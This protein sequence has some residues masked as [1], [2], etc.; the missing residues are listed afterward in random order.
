MKYGSISGGSKEAVEAAKQ[1]FYN[2]GNAFDAGI[3]AVFTSMTS[4]F[5]LTGAGGGGIMLGMSN[6]DTPVV[7]DFFVDCPSNNNNKIDFQKI[8]VDFGNTSQDFHIGKGSTATPG[9]IAGLLDIHQEKGILP[10]NIILE[11]AIKIAKEGVKLSKYQAY[12]NKLIEPILV[13][14]STGKELFT[15]HNSFLK[16]GSVK[17]VALWKPEDLGYGAVYLAKSQIDGNIYKYKEHVELGRLGK[18]KIESNNTIILGDPHVI[19]LKQDVRKFLNFIDF[20]LKELLN[21]DEI[22]SYFDQT[23]S[24]YIICMIVMQYFYEDRELSKHH[25]I[26]KILFY[27]KN[28]QRKTITTEAKYV[29]NAIAKGYLI[30]EQSLSDHRKI[31]IKPSKKM[32]KSV[33]FH[34]G[35]FF[36][37]LKH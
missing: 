22:T 20:R 9:N 36:S 3:G 12:I 24:H 28:L 6:N 23:A 34:F 16:E 10:L 2:G 26:D 21:Y 17:E 31:L 29:D 25:L 32:V 37:Y 11:P 8:N 7:Y 5:S 13:L 14:T 33:E 27:S 30:H 15:K 19:S 35:K 18:L 1:I 4:E